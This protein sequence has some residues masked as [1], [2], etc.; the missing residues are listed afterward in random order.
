MSSRRATLVAAVARFQH[1]GRTAQLRSGGRV[2]EWEG[3]GDRT[4]E[5]YS[6]RKA[7]IGSTRVAR[8]AGTSTATSDTSVT[9][10]NTVR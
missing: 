3:S 7:I 6:A 5:V 8:L 10:R 1:R 2:T 9:T 4:A